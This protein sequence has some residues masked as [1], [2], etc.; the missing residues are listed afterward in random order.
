MLQDTETLQN[1]PSPD[2]LAADSAQSLQHYQAQYLNGFPKSNSDADSTLTDIANHAVVEVPVAAP[3]QPYSGSPLHDTGSMALFLI[4]IFF[5][6]INYRSGHK[7][8]ENFIHNMF[9][10]SRRVNIFED[11]TIEESKSMFALIFNTCV[12]EG[13]LLYYGITYYYPGLAPHMHA[14]VFRYVGVLVA[15]TCVFY[16]AQWL[17][18]K[19]LG[20][21][22]TQNG[23]IDTNS[24]IDGFNASQSL[25]GLLLLPITIITLVYPSTIKWTIFIAITLYFLARIVFISK[26]F[27]IFFNNLSLSVYFILYLCSAEIVPQ[28]LILAFTIYICQVLQV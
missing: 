15:I 16:G 25:L 5:V 27:R 14:H 9:A 12:M 13:L 22:F 10:V 8:F 3:V 1:T 19:F 26:G 28:V 7:Y 24:W 6:V 4:A 18:Y 2:S 11:H 21:V 17:L 23:G 20:F